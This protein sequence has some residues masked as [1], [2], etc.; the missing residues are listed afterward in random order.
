MDGTGRF[1][2]GVGRGGAGA[3]NWLELAAPAVRG[4]L[5]AQYVS[6]HIQSLGG[7]APQ[8]GKV[9]NTSLTGTLYCCCLQGSKGGAGP[10]SA[11][12]MLLLRAHFSMDN[13]PLTVCFCSCCCPIVLQGSKGGAASLSAQELL[14]L[15]RADF[16]MEDVPQSGVV[17]EE[18]LDQLLDRAWMLEDSS[19]PAAAAAESGGD[20][21]PAAAG[22]SKAGAKAGRG[23]RLARSG[24]TN[25]VAGAAAAAA[26]GDDGA[27]PSRPAS[28]TGRDVVKGNLP[29]PASGVGYEVVQSL[30]T[31]VLS[32]VNS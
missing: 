32:N 1:R 29:Y 23:G 9:A 28:A 25:A 26:G 10:L 31:N 21:A 18:M 13:N 11:Q 15:L 19:A 20:Q 6:V 17:S 27:G 16:S 22:S 4:Q 8:L 5:G 2:K 12:D 30:D 14:S 24:S 7:L 3:L